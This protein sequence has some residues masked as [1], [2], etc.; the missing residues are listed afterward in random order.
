MSRADACVGACLW[1]SACLFAAFA[2]VL[3]WCAHPYSAVSSAG[4][5]LTV[6]WAARNFIRACREESDGTVR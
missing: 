2:A 3:W 5:A 4:C 6:A 1:L